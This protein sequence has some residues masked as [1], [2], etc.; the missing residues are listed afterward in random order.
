MW[1]IHN[2]LNHLAF[3]SSRCYGKDKTFTPVK[4]FISNKSYAFKFDSFKFVNAGTSNVFLTCD[5]YLCDPKKSGSGKCRQPVSFIS[6]RITCI[7]IKYLP[8]NLICKY[9]PREE[10]S[11]SPP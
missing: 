2:L 3:L 1:K 8:T 10:I 11:M 5:L 9:A 4:A 7:D 6:S